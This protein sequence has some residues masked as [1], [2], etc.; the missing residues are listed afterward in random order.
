MKRHALVTDFTQGNVPRSLLTF[1]L[2]L[3]LANLLQIAYNMADMMQNARVLITTHDALVQVYF[4]VAILY[5]LINFAINQLSI[6]MAR[7][8][9]NP[10]ISRSTEN[11]T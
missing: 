4:V 11:P 5:I 7:R 10:I 3:Y 2:P 8:S 9:G 1:A 6:T